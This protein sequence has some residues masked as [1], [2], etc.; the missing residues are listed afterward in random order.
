MVIA[1]LSMIAGFL[2]IGLGLIVFL[3]G[4]GSRNIRTSFLI[5]AAS[6]GAWAVFVAL[7]LLSS[8][9]TLSRIFV[10]IYYC[11]AL[12]ISYGFLS[13][14]MHFSGSQFSGPT[15]TL[16]LLPWFLM[17]IVAFIPGI[18]IGDVDTVN[19]TV[20]LV[21]PAYFA[22]ALLFLIY[23]LIGIAHL[24]SSALRTRRRKQYNIILAV[25]LA[26]SF[27]GGSYF[28]LILPWIG[29]YR[30]VAWGPL[31]AIVMVVSIFYVIAKY[32]VF[33]IR[34][35]VV[36]T[37]AYSLAITTL[38]AVYLG[39]VFFVIGEVFG[40][41]S[42]PAQVAVNIV[43]TLTLALV[44]QPVKK[45]FDRFT[46][47]LFY[48]DSYN[49]D[50]FYVHLSKVLTST[51][52]LRRL[53]R[54]TAELVGDTL[55]SEQAF[56]F[57]YGAS[58]GFVT[59][60]T[61]K[62]AKMPMADANTLKENPHMFVADQ[63][64]T[65]DD[66]SRLLKSHRINVIMPLVNSGDVKGFLCLGEHKTSSYS[67]RDLTVLK[68]I[69]NELV[70]AIQNSLS[71]QEVRELNASL[72]QRI[73]AATRELRL[74]NAQLQ[75]LDEAKDEFISMASH[76]LR[77]PLTSIKGYISMML[78]GDVG[79]ITPGQKHVLEEAFIGSERMVRLIGDFLNVSRLQTGKFVIEKRPTD[80]AK[81][82]DDELD[83][84]EPNAT[85][86]SLK[87]KYSHPK[88][89]PLLNIDAG[90]V[91]QV[92][93]NFADNAIFYSKENSV[94][95]IN[96]KVSRD[97][98]EYTVIDSGIGVPADEQS[99][100]FKKFF[101]ATN[102]RKQRPDGTGVGLFLA[103]KVIDAHWGEIIFE[104]KENKGSTFGFRLPIKKLKVNDA[105][106]LKDKPSDNKSD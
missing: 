53:L 24:V 18:L 44:F 16:A 15:Q 6:V 72:E 19:N 39:A 71:V 50:E 42:S 67:S 82:I 63:P 46:N 41:T 2:S 11:F 51:T 98:V 84:L 20:E 94:I 85:A 105:E 68:T 95:K 37:T 13:F 35:A 69:S 89:V 83:S 3:N 78:E 31:F 76:Q 33:D 104:S 49:V 54:R 80:I 10:S 12:M 64:D 66:I 90:K 17:C 79:S 97:W 100:L 22:Y 91:Q 92:I 1:L 4:S 36:R 56:F 60:G 93:M 45:F 9:P 8:D 48:K 34:L 86:R 65:P 73:D 58:H 102:A 101:R 61:D 25:S 7:F 74:S 38:A 96:L 57:V 21:Q 47:K 23:V 88:K 40:L 81:L 59:S 43:L 103:K 87:F 70:I 14:V 75:R 28:N 32:R 55:K 77:T 99:G 52:D 27:I 106:K 5:F 62:H 26:I 30:F 29:D